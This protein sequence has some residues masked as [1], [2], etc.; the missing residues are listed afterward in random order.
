M[1]S[2]KAIS[3]VRTGVDAGLWKY[4]LTTK[5]ITKVISR[6]KTTVF[7]DDTDYTWSP[8]EQYV[9]F[10]D[11]ITRSGYY[12]WENAVNVNVFDTMNSKTVNVS[13]INAREMFSQ[14]SSDGKYLYFMSNRQGDGIYALPLSNEA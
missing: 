12:F 3:F 14:W 7:A 1:P 6:T 11:E 13:R 2:K 4:D 9:A 8:D 10:S 5:Q